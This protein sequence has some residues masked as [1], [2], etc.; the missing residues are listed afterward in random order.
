MAKKKEPIYS[1][2]NLQEKCQFWYIDAEGKTTKKQKQIAEKVVESISERIKKVG[3]DCKRI[4][5]SIEDEKNPVNNILIDYY[6]NDDL[7]GIDSNYMRFPKDDEHIPELWIGIY[8]NFKVSEFGEAEKEVI[9]QGVIRELKNYERDSDW[10]REGVY[11]E[12]MA[13]MAHYISNLMEA[14]DGLVGS[15]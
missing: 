9:R 7:H 8:D 2:D 12:E 4:H 6:I 14:F 10:V 13:E 11:E 15:C 5:I 1:I 3:E